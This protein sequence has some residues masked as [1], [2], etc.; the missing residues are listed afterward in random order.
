MLRIQPIIPM[1]VCFLHAARPMGFFFSLLW[2]LTGGE[3]K[4]ES[5]Q[6]YCGGVSEM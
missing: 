4:N 5:Y 1:G 6:T 3:R 2:L